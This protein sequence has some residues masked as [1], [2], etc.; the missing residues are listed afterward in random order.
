MSDRALLL[1]G[2]PVV[3]RL[4]STHNASGIA[5]WSKDVPEQAN[6]TTLTP[7]SN[8]FLGYSTRGGFPVDMN[9]EK[10]GAVPKDIQNY[11]KDLSAPPAGVKLEDGTHL[12]Y[13]DF[14]PS[15]EPY[16]PYMHRTESID[17]GVV[18][19]GVMEVI[20]ESGETKVMNRGDVVIH[21]GTKHAWKNIAPN[22]GWTRMLFTIIPSKKVVVGNKTLGEDAPPLSGVKG[23]GSN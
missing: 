5:V 12:R 21:R 23:P 7:L 17:Y 16:T 9:A 11:L 8:F 14:A 15:K 4:I 22:G 19:E 3:N 13:L 2:L 1:N 18:I 6:F 10:E 20:L